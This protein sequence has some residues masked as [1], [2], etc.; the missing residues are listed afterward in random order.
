MKTVDYEK[1][2][3]L[4]KMVNIV[5]VRLFLSMNPTLKTYHPGG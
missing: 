5:F 3:N 2:M 1:F 4:K